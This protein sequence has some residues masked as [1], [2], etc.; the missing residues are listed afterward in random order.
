M[1]SILLWKDIIQI[2]EKI[3]QIYNLKYLDKIVPETHRL[4]ERFGQLSGCRSCID[5]GRHEKDCKKKVL[6]IRLNKLGKR[7][8][9]AL[10]TKT[11]LDTLAHE[12]AHLRF[13]F[14]YKEHKTLTKEITQTIREMGYDI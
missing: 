5:K 11:I 14:H 1:T 3:C 9:H 6:R 13:W 12:L 7:R 8:K 10:Q 4:T 2:S